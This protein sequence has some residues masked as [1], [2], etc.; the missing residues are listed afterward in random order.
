MK[1]LAKLI[2]I[3]AIAATMATTMAFVGCSND[4]KDPDDTGKT[5]QGGSEKPEPEKPESLYA[6]PE[7]GADYWADYVLEDY[8][9]LESDAGDITYQLTGSTDLNGMPLSLMLNLHDTT[10]IVELYI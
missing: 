9:S 8:Q 6:E 10:F 7:N 5:E 1:K 4:T 2:I 3:A